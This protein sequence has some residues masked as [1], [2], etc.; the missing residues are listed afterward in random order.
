MALTTEE[1][2]LQ[3]NILATKTD[4][5]TNPNMPYKTNA[6]L[7]KGLNPEFFTGNYTKIVN[8]LNQLATKSK[9]NEIT[10]TL[11]ANKVNS[12]LL[13]TDVADNAAIWA[14]V[15]NLMGQP[16]IIQGL[17][18]ILEGKKVDKVLGVTADD[19][20]KVLSVDQNDEGDL[21]I[22][23]VEM[24]A[25]GGDVA[26]LFATDVKYDNPN[27]PEFSNVGSVLDYL[28]A[29]QGVNDGEGNIVVNAIWE[30]IVNKPA[31]G[32]AL[33]LEEDMLCLELDDGN[34]STVELM[35]DNDI[36]ALINELN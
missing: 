21:I 7:N 32:T 30:D 16:T 18:D 2:L 13:D 23:A 35:T 11:V 14:N 20:G 6:T 27:R 9:N 34:M 29:N 36:D 1:L 4:E 22:K 28:L 15:Q 26:E 19:I 17:Q 33:K 8:A 10:A 12:I 31:V 3:M 25:G 5:A 24:V